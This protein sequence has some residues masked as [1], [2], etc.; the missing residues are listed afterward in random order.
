MV[1]LVGEW[2][3]RK[4]GTRRQRGLKFKVGRVSERR[5]REILES[6]RPSWRDF[7]LA[8]SV[9]KKKGIIHYGDYSLREL[10]P[11]KIIDPIEFVDILAEYPLTAVYHNPRKTEVKREI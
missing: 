3:T 5:I 1:L 9:M 6:F 4:R 7:L 2:R 10:K 8:R 11:R